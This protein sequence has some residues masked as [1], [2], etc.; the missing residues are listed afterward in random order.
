M[1]IIELF[2]HVAECETRLPDSAV[3]EMERERARKTPEKTAL[4]A[5]IVALLLPEVK[6]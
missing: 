6:G 4:I 1:K 3:R 5:E 2:D